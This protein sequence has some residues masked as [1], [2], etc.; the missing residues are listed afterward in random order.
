ML[1]AVSIRRGLPDD[2]E[3]AVKV[4]LERQH[5]LRRGGRTFAFLLEESVLRTGVGGPT[6]MAAQL[7]HLASA[8]T[9]PAVSLGVLPAR[10]DRDAARPVEDFWIFDSEQVS[11]ELVSGYLTVT[12]PHEIAMYAQ[13]FGALTELAVFGPRAIDLIEKV[14]ASLP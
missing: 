10:P 1:R 5:L 12:Q 11:V 8:A 13:L 7:A 4:R 6:V 2:V 14:A 9:L 3:D